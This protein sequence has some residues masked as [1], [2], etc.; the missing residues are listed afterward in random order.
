MLTVGLAIFLIARAN[1][2]WAT[3]TVVALCIVSGLGLL[4]LNPKLKAF[5]DT[6]SLSQFTNP[7]PHAQF[8]HDLRI[9]SW[10]ASFEVVENNWLLGVGEGNKESTLTNVYIKRGY[11]FASEQKFNSH[12]QYLDYFIGGGIFI[13][14]LFLF[15]LGQLTFRA[16]VG[17]NYPLLIFMLIFCFNL[18]FENILSRYSGILFF[19]IFVSV[20]SNASTDRVPK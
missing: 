7:N 11:T 8:G 14:G 5:S 6:L 12:N 2:G 13:F 16:F 9:L 17:R 3:K 15:G 20:W 4:T 19:S 1:W 10:S 18:L